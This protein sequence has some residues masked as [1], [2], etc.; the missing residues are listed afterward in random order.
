MVNLIKA[1]QIVNE[2]LSKIADE[3]VVLDSVEFDDTKY[4]VRLE[5]STYSITDSYNRIDGTVIVAHNLDQYIN[6]F[7]SIELEEDNSIWLD[8]LINSKYEQSDLSE[9]GEVL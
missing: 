4:Q 1:F 7:Y 5:D 9:F 8:I 2:S 6:K 3:L